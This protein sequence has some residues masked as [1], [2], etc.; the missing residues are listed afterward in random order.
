MVTDSELTI[1]A[2]E[3]AQ[4]LR[5]SLRRLRRFLRSPKGYLLVAL[6]ALT[7][8]ALPSAGGIGA[9]GV[10]LGWAVAGSAG[11][12]LILVR[13]GEGRWR[14]PSSALL[15][16]LIVGMILGPPEPWWT[17]LIAGVLATDAKHLLRL[18]RAQIFNPAAF[19][20]L[21]VYLLFGTGQSWWGALAEL[22]APLI[23]VLLAAGYLVADRAN[24][25]PA[26]L[27]FLAAYVALFT[28]TT[29]AGS[30]A[31]RRFVTAPGTHEAGS[32]VAGVEIPMTYPS[33]GVPH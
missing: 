15:T 9:A 30:H 23:A 6:L 13:L 31:P 25:L 14:L 29:F 3:R 27:T 12:E 8:L 32:A 5:R 2:G 22:P 18:G 24:K 33:P 10:I 19:G 26:A 4:P 11:M 28:V 20:L 17:A 1:G 7:A 16:G 21:A